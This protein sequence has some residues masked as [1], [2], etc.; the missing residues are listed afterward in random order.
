MA[1][2][3]RPAHL[4]HLFRNATQGHSERHR[5]QSRASKET[6]LIGDKPFIADSYEEFETTIVSALKSELFCRPH[7]ALLFHGNFCP[8]SKRLKVLNDYQTFRRF[9]PD[10]CVALSVNSSAGLI[11]TPADL[12]LNPIETQS[13]CNG[14]SVLGLSYL[15]MPK[16]PG[17]EIDVFNQSDDLQRLARSGNLRCLLI[18][19][20]VCTN[21]DNT[22]LRFRHVDKLID[23]YN[24]NLAVGGVVVDSVKLAKPNKK[25]FEV[26]EMFGLAFSGANVK[27]CSLVLDTQCQ[28]DTE[29]KLAEFRRNLDFNPDPNSESETFAFLFICTGRGMVTY[30]VSNVEASLFRKVF[31]GVK[32]FGVFGHGEYG[33]DYWPSVA[34]SAKK[35]AAGKRALKRVDDYGY[36]L[37]YTTILV[38]VNLPIK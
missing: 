14:G 10:D 17:V 22:P 21:D 18:F 34:K 20:S 5:K 27:A 26:S 24:S 37:F 23:R 33:Q 6:H 9:L 36:W 4:F 3:S 30:G 8:R 1:V 7:F 29:R 28:A 11:G 12:S 16:M 13:H 2:R 38:M 25:P 35:P 31:P 32:L 19:S 15:L